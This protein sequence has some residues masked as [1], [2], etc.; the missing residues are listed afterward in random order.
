MKILKRIQDSFKR[1]D[2][3][4]APNKKLKTIS[5][6]FKANFGLTLVI[7]KGAKIADESLT[8]NQ[9]D[10]KV[11]TQTTTKGEGLRVKASMKIGAAEDL[12]MEHYGLKVQ[13]K[14]QSGTKLLPNEMTIGDAYRA[15]L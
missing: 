12:F 13:I 3:V 5:A 8:I 6:E 14:N 15:E 2:F 9:L 1:A 4:V 7:Y 11:T 10:Q